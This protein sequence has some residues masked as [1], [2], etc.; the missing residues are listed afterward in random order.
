M[1]HQGAKRV[2]NAIDG[3][4]PWYSRLDSMRAPSALAACYPK[5]VRKTTAT[6]KTLKHLLWCAGQPQRAEWYL[7]ATRYRHSVDRRGLQLLASGTTSNEALHAEIGRWFEHSQS[8][9]RATLRLKLHILRFS[10]LL[11]HNEALY[12]PSSRQQQQGEVLARKLGSTRLW[13]ARSWA[14]WCR[15]M[16]SRTGT[17]L[18]SKGPLLRQLHNQM[19]AVKSLKRPASAVVKKRPSA[20]PPRAGRVRPLARQKRT[21]FTLKRSGK[22]LRWGR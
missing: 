18:K 15:T 3:A 19:S 6:G 16:E 7:N 20:A 1:S 21:V 5:E 14:S 22:V 2:L 10:K 17:V 9:H 13:T 4:T 8:M 12:R 11:A